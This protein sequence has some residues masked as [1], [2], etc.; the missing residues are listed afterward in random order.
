M[1]ITGQENNYLWHIY[2]VPS[3]ELEKSGVM[4]RWWD[5]KGSDY[6]PC[7]CQQS[8]VTIIKAHI[9][10]PFSIGVGCDMTH[11][12]VPPPVL[13]LTLI[14]VSKHLPIP[15]LGGPTPGTPDPPVVE[16]CHPLLFS[17]LS[18]L[19]DWELLEGGLCLVHLDP[20][21]ACCIPV[22]TQ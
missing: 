10:G 13:C 18:L 22:D 7:F 14:W 4:G 21:C 12:S 2:Y 9:S 3:H 6:L 15:W 17:H 11:N 20:S 16:I 5:T 1:N 19:L 8:C